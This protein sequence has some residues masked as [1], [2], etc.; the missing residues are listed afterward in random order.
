[1]NRIL[2]VYQVL[3]EANI[4]V[5]IYLILRDEYVTA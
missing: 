1:M 4:F 2:Y 3:S 5:E